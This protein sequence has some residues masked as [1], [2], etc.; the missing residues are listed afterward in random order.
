[1]DSNTGGTFSFSLGN[2]FLATAKMIKNNSWGT[3]TNI[4]SGTSRKLIWLYKG[5]PTWHDK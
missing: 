4:P 1:M 5:I 2:K 3:C